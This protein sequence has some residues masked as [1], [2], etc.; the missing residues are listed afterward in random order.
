MKA[1]NAELKNLLKQYL[2]APINEDLIVPCSS[3]SDQ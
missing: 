2:A 1:Q 3:T